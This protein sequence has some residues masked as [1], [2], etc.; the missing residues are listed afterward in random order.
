MHALDGGTWFGPLEIRFHDIAIAEVVV[1]AIT[2]V[3]EVMCHHDS[4]PP[5]AHEYSP[6]KDENHIAQ[7]LFENSKCGGR[8]YSSCAAL[9]T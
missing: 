4:S 7:T 8:S 9:E 3:S 2:H 5:S 6:P 1:E